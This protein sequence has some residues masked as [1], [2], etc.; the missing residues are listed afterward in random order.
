MVQSRADIESHLKK[1][2]PFIAWPHSNFSPVDVDL[3]PQAGYRGAVKYGGGIEDVRTINIYG[4]KRVM[5]LARTSTSSY[6]SLLG[7]E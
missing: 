7:L 6:A 3:L 2:V 1:P 4:I 5:I